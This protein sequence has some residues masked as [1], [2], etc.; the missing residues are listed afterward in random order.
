MLSSLR[1]RMGDRS[2]GST[3]VDELADLGI[4]VPKSTGAPP[5]DAKDGKLAIDDDQAHRRARDRPDERQDASSTSFASRRATYVEVADRQR[6]RRAR[7]ARRVPNAEL[8]RITDQI[9]APT[10]RLTAKETRL[11]AQF[12]A[13]ESALPQTQTQQAWLTGQINSL[14]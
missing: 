14:G 10:T 5:D 4:A 3:G 12:A 6:P 11:K 8:K 2:P 1:I 7:R 9:A 13:M